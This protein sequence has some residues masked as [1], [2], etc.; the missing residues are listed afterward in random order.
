MYNLH[1]TIFKVVRDCI[2]NI[3]NF[4]SIYPNCL[5]RRVYDTKIPTSVSFSFIFSLPPLSPTPLFFNHFNFFF[6]AH[7]LLLVNVG[8]LSLYQSPV[9]CRSRKVEGNFMHK[10]N[11]HYCHHFQAWNLYSYMKEL[12]GLPFQG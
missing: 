6:D 11:N 9:N 1:N 3:Y 8:L 4:D 5:D 2:L 7:S 10:V 12:D